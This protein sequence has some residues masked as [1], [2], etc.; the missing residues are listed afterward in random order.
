MA[1]RAMVNV[2]VTLG[3][4]VLIPVGDRHGLANELVPLGE[5]AALV[6]F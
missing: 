3:L 6:D 2:C 5:S 4:L 1:S